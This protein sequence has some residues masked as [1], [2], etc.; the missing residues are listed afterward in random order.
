M[1]YGLF[2]INQDMVRCMTEEMQRAENG[3]LPRAEKVDIAGKK[4][5]DKRPKLSLDMPRTGTAVW[6]FGMITPEPSP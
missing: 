6:T 5:E 3:S 4:M 1:D 2:K